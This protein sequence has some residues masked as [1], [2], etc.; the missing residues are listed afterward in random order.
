MATP[1]PPDVDVAWK[2][3]LGSCAA[4][5][6]ATTAVIAR[7]V[8]R[9][10]S[11]AS[12]WWD[13]WTIVLAVIVN[14]GME[15]VRWIMIV[16]Y[17]YG[18]HVHYISKANVI[19]FWKA[20]LAVQVMYFSNAVV[21]KISLLLLYYRIFGVVVRFRIALYISA[22]LVSGYWVACTVVAIAGCS[23][24]SKNWDKLGP[25]KCIDEINFFRW[26]GICNL[27]I[28]V[29]VLCL[30]MP[31][32]WRLKIDLKQK[33]VLS[34]IFGLGAFVCIASVLRVLAF[35]A[36]QIADGTFST[37]GTVTWSSVEQGLGIVCACLPT[38][39]PLFDRVFPS[40]RN[41]TN[42]SSSHA[43]GNSHN[44]QNE[45]S[46]NGA[47]TPWRQSAENGSTVGFARLQDEEAFPTPP[48]ELQH[49]TIFA[50]VQGAGVSTSAEKG[51]SDGMMVSGGIL[52]ESTIEQH[53]I[54]D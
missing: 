3:W 28:D 31:M 34:A 47:K 36:D 32:V 30:P 49:H 9:R 4:V 8:A 45:F 27:I 18:R 22:F 5:V 10:M 12:F 20:F 54:R 43:L 38:L 35:N 46:K 19:H 23:P 25:G 41:A 1:I 52:K 51:G 21:T 13:D 44:A 14:W 48:I 15:V 2:V 6:L 16:R 24:I 42:T 11:A 26:N 29:L 40:F 33:L 53:S 37:V 7:L 50:P 17:D 39:R